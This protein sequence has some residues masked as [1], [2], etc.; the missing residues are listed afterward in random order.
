MIEDGI[1]QLLYAQS[2]VTSLI[3]SA[4]I[5]PVLLPKDALGPPNPFVALTYQRVSEV[6]DNIFE[7]NPRFNLK[8]SRFQFDAWGGGINGYSLARQL[9]RAVCAALLDFRGTL[10]DADSTMVRDVLPDTAMDL[11]EDGPRY[12][13]KTFD[14]I[15][16]Y[17]EPR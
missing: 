10:P 16:W 12:F 1:V 6:T 4:G 9:K 11:F 5:Y 2:G 8:R 17:L 7:A 14:L 15:V 3:G 13:R